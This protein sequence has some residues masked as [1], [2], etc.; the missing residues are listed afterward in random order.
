MSMCESYLANKSCSK[1]NC[2]GFH[3]KSVPDSKNHAF[4][5]LPG[6]FCKAYY[7]RRECTARCY[8]LH[9][10]P[11]D[12]NGVCRLF[13]LYGSCDVAGCKYLHQ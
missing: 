13:K 8:G 3:S 11:R 7:Q 4:C 2:S 9:V 5:L 12:R 6:G 1:K 10:T